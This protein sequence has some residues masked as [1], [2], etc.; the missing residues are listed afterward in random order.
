MTIDLKVIYEFLLQRNLLKN[1]SK[2]QFLIFKTINMNMQDVFESIS[3][4]NDIVSAVP[5]YLFLGLII[6]EKLDWS[7][8]ISKV[9]NKINPYIGVLKKIWHFVDKK[10]LMLIYY[11]YIDSALIYGLPIWGSAPQKYLDRLQILQNKAIKFIEKKAPP[12]TNHGIIF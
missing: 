9:C 1:A 10:T 5:E 7:S 4:V 6:N 3:L 8:H 2:T 12:N 11:A